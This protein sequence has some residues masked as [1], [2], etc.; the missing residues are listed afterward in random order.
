MLDLFRIRMLSPDETAVRLR[1]GDAI[2]CVDSQKSGGNITDLPGDEIAA[3]DHHPTYVDVEYLWSDLQITGACATLIAEHYQRSG[4]PPDRDAATALLY[5]IKID[6][7]RFTR[8]VTERDIQA[9]AYLFPLIDRDA[10]SGLEKNDIEF[11]DLKAY[12][13]AIESIRLYGYVGLSW[14]P[15]PCPDALI[16][17]LSDLIL[18]LYEVEVAVVCC[19]REDGIKISVR[20]ERPDVHAGDLTHRALEDIGSGGGHAEMAGGL[21][22]ADRTASLGRYPA[23]ALRDRFLSAL[24]AVRDH[25]A[26]IADHADGGVPKP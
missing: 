2:I 8:G 16:A 9:F 4:S 14:I 5:G 7:L 12:G 26:D 22:P 11:Q 6:T 18:S 25:G 13:A 24:E 10:L 21:V 23:D 3:I 20:S 17:V 19:D 15:F 1:D